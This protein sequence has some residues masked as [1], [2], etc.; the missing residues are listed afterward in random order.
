MNKI[1]PIEDSK[2]VFQ[3]ET[4]YNNQINNNIVINN[5]INCSNIYGS[6]SNSAIKSEYNNNINNINNINLF[7]SPKNIY[8]NDNQDK[9]LPEKNQNEETAL[10]IVS[11]YFIIILIYKLDRRRIIQSAK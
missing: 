10:K 9:N 1:N 11:K 7:Q 5:Q 8:N 2:N 4:N 3:I 6:A